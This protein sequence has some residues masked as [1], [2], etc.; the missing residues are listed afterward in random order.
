MLDDGAAAV[1]WTGGVQVNPL[2]EKL[3][4]EK[5]EKKKLIIVEDTLQARGHENVF[6]L[7]DIAHYTNADTGLNGT[8]QL[9]Y[10]QASLA[11]R[12]IKALLAGTKL[13]T[14][15]F[16]E[17][18]KALSLGTEDAAV[19]IG[20]HVIGGALAREARFAAY[21]VRLPTWQHRLKV[22]VNWLTGG[23]APQSLEETR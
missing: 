16:K 9:A 8:A 12:N 14:E 19:E 15:H 7:G 5:D 2:V 13:N 3:N 20:G 22:G 11:A 18:G 10:Q 1:V 6:A 17:R 23:S 21:A 4:L